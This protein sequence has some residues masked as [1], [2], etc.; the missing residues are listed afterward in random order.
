M[1]INSD[2]AYMMVPNP[3]QRVKVLVTLRASLDSNKE[4]K[5][6]MVVMGANDKIY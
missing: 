3:N 5:K 2:Q 1:Q 6:M 4:Y